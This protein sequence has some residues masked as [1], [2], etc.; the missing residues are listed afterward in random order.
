MMKKWLV[1]VILLLPAA[2]AFPQAQAP[3]SPN[4]GGGDDAL[5]AAKAAV[6]Q[7]RQQC[8]EDTEALAAHQKASRSACKKQGHACDAA[9]AKVRADRRKVKK[10]KAIL[11]QAW[12][13]E[14]DLLHG[15]FKETSLPG[16]GSSS[17]PVFLPGAGGA[18][19]QGSSKGGSGGHHHRSHGKGQ[20][21]RP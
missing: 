5:S 4:P 15:S 6:I 18:G 13:H 3:Q 11:S 12:A 20:P 2:S 10:D 9:K 21:A 8:D 14:W 17:D 7:A 16:Q 19:G 1:V